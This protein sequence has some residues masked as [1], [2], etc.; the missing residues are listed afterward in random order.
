MRD[1]GQAL[2][3]GGGWL[4]SMHYFCLHGCVAFA[5]WYVLVIGGVVVALCTFCDAPTSPWTIVVTRIFVVWNYYGGCQASLHH[6]CIAHWFMLIW[7]GAAP[8]CSGSERTVRTR[9]RR[10]GS[11]ASMQTSLL[12]TLADYS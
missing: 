11:A 10:S 2:C 3:R 12:Y 7:K 5:I 1:M 4:V 6:A 9:W 8:R